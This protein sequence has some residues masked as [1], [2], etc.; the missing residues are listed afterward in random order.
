[1]T[2]SFS[3]GSFTPLPLVRSSL[4]ITLHNASDDPNSKTLFPLVG[5]APHHHSIYL[6]A[7]EWFLI[8]GNGRKIPWTCMLPCL[9]I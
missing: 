5:V 4:V 6:V 8:L 1:M 7:L 3:R 2:T 9:L